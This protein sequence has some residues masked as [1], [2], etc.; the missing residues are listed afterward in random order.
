[1][2]R[3]IGGAVIALARRST[4]LRPLLKALGMRT[5]KEWFRPG[6]ITVDA[7][8]GRVLRLTHTAENY[9]TFQLFWN[10]TGYYEPVTSHL[11]ARLLKDASLFLDI[12]ANI[13]F[14]SLTAVSRRP[15]LD[16]IAF[17]PHP[18]LH[19][20]LSDN[21]RANGMSSVTC[22]PLALSDETGVTRLFLS[23]SDMG[24]SVE[25]AFLERGMDS[26]VPAES[27][28][29]TV[30]RVTLDSYMARRQIEGRLVIKID[31]EGHEVKALR[32]ARQT[33]ARHLPDIVCEI[34]VDHPPEPFPE[35]R[36]LGYRFH[37]VTD[38]GLASTREL[39][40]LHRGPLW[41]PNGLFTTRDDADVAALSGW[42]RKSLAG[43]DLLKT[44]LNLAP[45]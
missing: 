38:Q 29:I 20:I 33:I 1:M 27:P 24:A 3:L 43:I 16:V 19:R 44:S 8:G 13:G 5:R 30:E 25:T 37:H 11:L 2:R 40:P 15:D 26:P 35:L 17:E 6:P 14:H 39:R 23:E 9:L 45:A 31:V 10:G 32:G 28:S 18:K 36:D 22:E 7:G 21:V 42:L 4:R 41:F 34:A 12:G